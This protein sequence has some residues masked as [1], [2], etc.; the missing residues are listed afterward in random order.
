MG[1][2]LSIGIRKMA[3]AVIIIGSLIL[4]TSLNQIK[5][6]KVTVAKEH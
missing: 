3:L 6:T 5:D 1:S 2:G 4:Y